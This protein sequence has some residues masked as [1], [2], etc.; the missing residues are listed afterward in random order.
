MVMRGLNCQPVVQSVCMSG[1]FSD[2]FTMCGIWEFVVAIGDF[3][4][5]Y[6]IW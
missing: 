3:N 6:D 2:F 4:E 1:V 5:L